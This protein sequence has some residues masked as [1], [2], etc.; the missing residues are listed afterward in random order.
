LAGEAADTSGGLTQA[1]VQMI[2][3][4]V[5]VLAAHLGGKLC[6]RLELSEVVGQ[7]LGGALVGP[8]ALHL[9]GVLPAGGAYDQAIGS[10]HFFIFV[11]LGLVAFGIGEE[12]HLS[13][14]RKVGRNAFVICLVQALLTGVLVTA[15]FLLFSSMSL[16]DALL[17]GS[18][19]MATAP[20]VAFV[21]MNQF[22][23]EGRLRQLLGN[24]VVID[25]LIEVIIFSLLIQLCLRRAGNQGGPWYA[26]LATVAEEVGFGLLVGGGIYLGLRMFI[27][28]TALDP[29]EE[30]PD[31]EVETNFLGRML[32]EVPS[33]SVEI[34]ILVIG[35]VSLGAGL[36]LWLHWPFL[37]TTVFAGFLVANFHSHAIF[38]SL[39]IDNVAPL[40]A[41]AF[42]A[43]IGVNLDLSELTAETMGLV[44][45]YL[46]SRTVGKIFGTWMGC[47]L[48]GEEPKVTACLPSLMLPE[49]G[50]AAVE[51]VY[52]GAVLGN[53][54]IP[55]IILPSIMVFTVGGVFMVDRGLRKWRTW[56]AGEGDELVSK[57]GGSGAGEA[58]RMLLSYLSDDKIILNLRGNTKREVIEEL[59]DHAIATADQHIDRA[60]ALQMLNERER[61]APTGIGNG[62][63]IPHCRLMALERPVLVFGVHGGKVECGGMDSLPCCLFLLMLTP[64]RDAGAHLRLLSAAAHVFSDE[65]TR[66]ALRTAH[67]ADAVLE[68]LRRCAA[69]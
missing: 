47:K 20:A 16:L 35:A 54:G 32:V 67:D 4:G 59:T 62:V 5:V 26:G 14:I 65:E 68:V 48:V 61:L 13:R 46:C 34:L 60:Q 23:I 21:L 3:L 63:A 53:P 24:L 1:P 17:I 40:L 22:N 52:A 43:L 44:G 29:Q 58:A 2:A 57:V 27:R 64:G 37:I 12:L 55:A 51:A 66:Q 10:F 18:M 28:S 69:R 36:S 33:P 31:G 11:F 41:L 45:V 8:Y 42:F 7:L 9:A 49:A 38:D 39:K 6:R 30:G 50:V 56:V 25:D 19:G 15:A